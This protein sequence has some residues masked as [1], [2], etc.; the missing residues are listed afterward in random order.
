MTDE[1]KRREKEIK[2][3]IYVQNEIIRQAKKRLKALHEELEL[4][5]NNKDN[6]KTLCKNMDY[7]AN[8][9][10]ERER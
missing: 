8:D 4:L 3:L 5:G 10:M 2:Y 7:T 9:D 1:E 6:P